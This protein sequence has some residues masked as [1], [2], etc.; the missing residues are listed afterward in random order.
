QLEVG[1]L[2]N[3]V[4]EIVELATDQASDDE[5]LRRV[6]LSDVAREVAERARRRSARD[7]TVTER[8]P[9]PV[10]ARP[11]MLGRAAS[12]LVGNAVKY[13]PPG[14]AIEIAIDGRRLEVRDRG[15][16]IAASDRAHVFDRFYRSPDARTL[17]GSGLG[18]AIV[19]Q[20]VERHHGT[21]WAAGRTG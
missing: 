8:D 17:P 3:A 10:L 20:I 13:S 6:M 21:V 4:T 18:L 15:P 5:T 11:N 16:G 12:N 2:T 1:E 19:A 9:E 7:L 14:T